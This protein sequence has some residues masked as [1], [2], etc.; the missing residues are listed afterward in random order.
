MGP[1]GRTLVG[2]LCLEDMGI[3]VERVH[4]DPPE[5]RAETTDVPGRDGT[6]TTGA[7]LGPRTITLECRAFGDEW[8]DFDRIVDELAAHM[9]TG[10]DLRLS[11]RTR[12]GEY[13]MA[14]LDSIAQDDR[15]GGTGIGYLELAF[16]A[17][18]PYRY[19]PERTATVPSGGSATIRV[20]GTRPCTV[21]VKAE[22][23]RRDASSLVWGLRFDEGDVMHVAPAVSSAVPVSVDGAT[24]EVLVSGAAS[25]LTLDSDWPELA[26]GRHTVRMDQGTG[27]ATI[28]WQERSI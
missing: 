2:D 24:R 28:A 6:V 22:V 9:L 11:P 21:S 18:D 26:P 23:A 1:I 10:E 7:T 12:P 8:A 13:Y 16:T 17:S 14:R 4:D 27:A 20:G 15:L 25:M 5:L 19:G 3:V